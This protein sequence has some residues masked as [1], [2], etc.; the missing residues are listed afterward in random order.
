M[1]FWQVPSQT[2]MSAQTEYAMSTKPLPEEQFTQKLPKIYDQPGY[3]E[4][5]AA[6]TQ[7][8]QQVRLHHGKKKTSPK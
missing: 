2:P 1:N 4:A 6:L 3:G 7:A 8:N 5:F